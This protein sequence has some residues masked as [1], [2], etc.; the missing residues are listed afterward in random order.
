MYIAI[1]GQS[2]IRRA[3]FHQENGKAKKLTNSILLGHVYLASCAVFFVF[4]NEMP[5]V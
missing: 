2:L 1:E 3:Y 4:D 5:Q